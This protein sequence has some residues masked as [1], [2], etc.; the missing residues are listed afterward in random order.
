MADYALNRWIFPDV[1]NM[2]ADKLLEMK[3][4][5]EKVSRTY[6][7]KMTTLYALYYTGLLNSDY[8]Q[9]SLIFLEHIGKIPEWDNGGVK[10]I[11]H[12]N[13]ENTVWHAGKVSYLIN[14]LNTVGIYGITSGYLSKS[15]HIWIH[16]GQH[17]T[18]AHHIMNKDAS[19]V[20]WDNSDKF[21]GV[22]LTF[23]EWLSLFT[24]PGLGIH[25]AELEYM[26]EGNV[27][28]SRSDMTAYIQGLHD[29]YGSKKPYL[30]GC[31]SEKIQHVFGD[32]DSANIHV[33]V[34]DGYTLTRS[35]LPAFLR[36]CVGMDSLKTANFNITYN[37]HK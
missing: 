14:E 15:N 4:A 1:F 6:V 12:V 19:I 23:D 33:E 26:I 29:M 17:R 8:S 24:K 13:L 25:T 20:M 2:D 27:N 34:D 7:P 3:S 31:V 36:L 21:T 10:K 30:K 32:D 28:E 9:S 35:D 22:V 37:S 18:F 11:Y 16:P 5:F